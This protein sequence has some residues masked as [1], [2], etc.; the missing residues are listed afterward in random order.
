MITILPLLWIVRPRFKSQEDAI[1]YPP[2]VIFKP[3]LEGYVNLFTVRTRQTPDFIAKLPPPTTWYEQAR[4]RAR[5]G[6]RRAVEGRAALRQLADH[7]LRLDIPRGVPR[8][9]RGLCVLAL[10]GAARRRSA[11]LHPVD[12]DDAADR[13]RDPD[14]PDVPRSSA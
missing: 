7:R 12:P 11:V 3:T 8:H 10:P 13:G 9:A 2:K 6:D 5:H 1:A 4:A 14:L